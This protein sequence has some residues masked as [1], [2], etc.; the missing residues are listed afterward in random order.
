MKNYLG[1]N[2]IICQNITDI[3]DKIIIKSNNE[4]ISFK[5]LSSKYEQDFFSDMNK[6]GVSYPD[7]INI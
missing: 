3:D 1:Y 2:L 6:L 4:G 5:E 7:I